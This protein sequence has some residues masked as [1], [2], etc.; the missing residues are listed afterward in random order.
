MLPA[1][2]LR[3]LQPALT[4]SFVAAARCCLDGGSAGT[5]SSDDEDETGQRDGGAPSPAAVAVELAGM[6]NANSMRVVQSYH[7][8]MK[9]LEVPLLLSIP[10]PLSPCRSGPSRNGPDRGGRGEEGISAP[11]AAAAAAASAATPRP[12]PRI[13]IVHGQND[14]LIPPQAGREMADALSPP[15][16]PPPSGGAAASAPPPVVRFRTVDR[17]GHMVMM[18]R[19]R[20]V[21]SLLLEFLAQDGGGARGQQQQR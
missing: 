16:P 19:P 17:A 2:F 15:P 3:C 4:R 10:P 7:S 6:C 9:W 1:F 18:E 20:A 14:R 21:A 12:P 13:L 5:C 11:A 8:E